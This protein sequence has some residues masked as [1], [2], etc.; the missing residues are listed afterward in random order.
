LK[1]AKSGKSGKYSGGFAFTTSAKNGE[2]LPNEYVPFMVNRILSGSPQHI[3]LANSFN[4]V[5]MKTVGKDVMA[6]LMYGIFEAD[7]PYGQ[8]FK[9]S[10]DDSSS[11]SEVTVKRLADL[12]SCPYNDAEIYMRNGLYKQE[13]VDAEWKSIYEP[14]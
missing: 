11:I 8:Y 13:D 5:R 1:P 2:F 10:K 3:N 14:Y 7:R 4:D 6:K 9:T 12:L